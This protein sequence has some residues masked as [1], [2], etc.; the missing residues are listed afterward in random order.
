MVCSVRGVGRTW[1]CM[2]LLLG[3]S[4]LPLSHSYAHAPRALISPRGHTRARAQEQDA[5]VNVARSKGSSYGTGNNNN[6]KSSYNNRQQ[7]SNSNGYAMPFPFSGP[8]EVVREKVLQELAKLANARDAA[9]Y[10]LVFKNAAA[11]SLVFGSSNIADDAL[12]TLNALLE[13]F[14]ASQISDILWSVSRTGFTLSSKPHRQLIMQLVHRLCEVPL[15]ELTPKVVT[16]AV[17]GIAKV[18]MR[19]YQIPESTQKDILVAVKAVA[20]RLNAR[21]VGNLLHSLSKIKV[22]WTVLGAPTQQMLLESFARTT[23]ELV[24]QQ[25]AMAIYSLGLMGLDISACAPAVRDK[26]LLVAVAVLRKDDK[27]QVDGADRSDVQQKVGRPSPPALPPS[28]TTRTCP[29]QRDLRTR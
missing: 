28:L 23:H 10:T 2:L 13:L 3:A 22:P 7:N 15:Q 4:Q 1:I 14:S 17:G 11:R 26:L 5:G 27:P 9:E 25:G 6:R 24:D 19:W 8:P 20:L 29:E 16:T 21:E 18:N 12:A